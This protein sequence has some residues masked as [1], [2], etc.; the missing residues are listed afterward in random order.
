MR[1]QYK[2]FCELRKNLANSKTEET[3]RNSAYECVCVLGG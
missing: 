3:Q 1:K 2:G